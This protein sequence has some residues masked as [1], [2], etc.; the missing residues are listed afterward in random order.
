MSGNPSGRKGRAPAAKGQPPRNFQ[1]PATDHLMSMVME[2][3]TEF[4]V[5]RDRLDTVER[6]IES[7]GIFRQADIDA[8]KLDDAAAAA[9]VADHLSRFWSPEMRREIVDYLVRGGSGL[10]ATAAAGVTSLRK[11]GSLHET[12]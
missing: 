4:S 6:L 3:M 8:Y 9:K 5:L 2:L 11:A 7:H 10:S 1:D 12:A